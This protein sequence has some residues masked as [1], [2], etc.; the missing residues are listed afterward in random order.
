MFPLTSAHGEPSFCVVFIAAVNFVRYLRSFLTFTK[1][2][3]SFDMCCC[4]PRVGK[5]NFTQCLWCMQSKVQCYVV[6]VAFLIRLCEVPYIFS[7]CNSRGAILLLF[8]TFLEWTG[9]VIRHVL[10]VMGHLHQTSPVCT[11]ESQ[12]RRARFLA[13]DNVICTSMLELYILKEAYSKKKR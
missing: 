8:L 9:V 13:I 2:E 10:E 11:R 12:R 7:T 6:F 4:I 3:V 1:F 5:C